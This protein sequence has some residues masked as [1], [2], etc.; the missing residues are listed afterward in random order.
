[1]TEI[2]PFRIAVPDDDLSDLHLRLARTRWP[3]AECVDE[4]S[5]GIPLDYARQ[6]ATCWA[7]EYD[8]RARE[9]SLNRFAQFISARRTSMPSRC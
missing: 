6:L 3:E 4:W 1:M 9:A 5:Q 8:W 7:D 2:R